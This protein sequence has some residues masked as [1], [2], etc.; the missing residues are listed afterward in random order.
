M[1]FSIRDCT[2]IITGASSGLG[3]EF[4]RQLAREANTL[5]LVA[6]RLDAMESVKAE[7]LSLKAELM[8]ELP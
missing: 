4:A 2:A 5:I 1:K 7:L 8:V 3:A 6:R